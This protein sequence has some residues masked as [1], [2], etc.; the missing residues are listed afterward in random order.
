MNFLAHLYL[1]GDDPEILVGNMMGDFVKGVL[2]A[3][4]PPRITKGLELHRRIDSFAGR[5][6]SFIASKRRISS[7]YGHYRGVLVDLYYDHFLAAEWES[8][9]DEP[10]ELFVAKA[11]R[12]MR[13]HAEI[14]PQRLRARL[15]EIFTQWLPSYRY[16]DGVDAVL[17]RMAARVG[18]PNP[19]DGGAAELA[20]HYGELRGDCF[21][22]FPDARR[23]VEEIVGA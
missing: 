20:L 22:F 1:S 8:F 10:F 15:E 2:N 16:V 4:Y 23:Y 21:R 5:H 18:R 11:W 12:I 7:D 13:E 14:L 19:L 9:S 3:S 6:P 17:R